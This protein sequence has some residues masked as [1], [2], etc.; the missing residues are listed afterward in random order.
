MCD[1]G[2]FDQFCST[3]SFRGCASDTDCNPPPSGNCGTCKPNQVCTGG[4][5]NCFL[6]PIVRSGTPGT[7]NSVL[8]ATFC[9][10]PVSAGAINGVTGLP[11]PGALLQPVAIFRSGAQ[12]GNGVLNSGETCDPPNDSA[13]PGACLPN[14]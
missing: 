11:G 13:C 4:F 6:D 12:C 9:I 1:A 14:C 7:Q 5:R 8:A 3:E 2:P 10:P